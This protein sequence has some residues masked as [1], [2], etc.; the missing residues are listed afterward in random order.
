MTAAGQRSVEHALLA[1][2]VSLPDGGLVLTGRLPS[3]GSGGWSAEHVVGGIALM[4]GA[5]LV[6]WALQA[7]Y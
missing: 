2:A 6:E 5:A 7:A 4:P 3:A 1:A